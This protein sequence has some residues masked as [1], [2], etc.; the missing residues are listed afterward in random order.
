MKYGVCVLGGVCAALVINGAYADEGTPEG[1]KT[2]TASVET[3]IVVTTGNTRTKNINIKGDVV[4]APGPWR[5]ALEVSALNAS[6]KGETTAE[7]YYADGKS[8]YNFTKHNYVFGHVNYDNNRFSGF[9]YLLTE[10]A[11]YGRNLINRPTLALDVEAGA[12][13]RQTKIIQPAQSENEAVA[14]VS[15]NLL[16][17]ISSTSTFNQ[18]LSS[19]IGQKRSVTR[20]VS[21]LKTQIAGNLA[22]NL[23]YTAEYTSSVPAGVSKI[24]TQTSIT[25]VYSF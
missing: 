9:S 4:Y 23:S 11:G 2:L 19:T 5:H 13:A 24:Y 8:Q 22:T 15:G 25:L 7:R 20:S 18:Q 1:K 12:G 10:T 14:Q 6:T 3:G 17:T 16:W 21:S